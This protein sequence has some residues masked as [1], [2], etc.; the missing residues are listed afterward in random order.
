MT[1]SIAVV[2]NILELTAHFF[3]TSL[4]VHLNLKRDKNNKN[5]AVVA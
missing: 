1:C 3:E 4:A 2:L 5:V